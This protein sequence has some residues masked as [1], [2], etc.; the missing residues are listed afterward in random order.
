MT[1]TTKTIMILSHLKHQTRTFTWAIQW[2]QRRQ[3]SLLNNNRQTTIQPQLNQL[4]N[5]TPSSSPSRQPKWLH[6]SIRSK[7]LSRPHKTSR[8]LNR[9][10]PRSELPQRSLNPLSHSKIHHQAIEE[11]LSPRDSPATSGSMYRL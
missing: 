5:R 10:D 9:S 1:M 7:R 8:I 2:I 3:S 4:C 11:A 6:Q